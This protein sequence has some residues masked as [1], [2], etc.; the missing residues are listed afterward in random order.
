MTVATVGRPTK[1][2][3]RDERTEE[4]ECRAV[5][6]AGNGA[7]SSMSIGAKLSEARGTSFATKWLTLFVVLPVIFREKILVDFF[8]C[9]G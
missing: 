2:A 9:W 6:G 8:E 5:D 4:P 7:I 3:S 1:P